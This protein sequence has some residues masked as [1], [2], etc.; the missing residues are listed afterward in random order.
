MKKLITLGLALLASYP[1]PSFASFPVIYG[2]PGSQDLKPCLG[3]DGPNIG[4]YLCTG[5][6]D[7]AAVSFDA[8]KGSIYMRYGPTGGAVY[9]KKDD[10]PSAN[11]GSTVSGPSG[12]GG[13]TDNA[14]V[15]WDG[16]TGGNLQDS[17]ATLSDTGV[18]SVP[19]IQ[20]TGQNATTVPFLDASKNLVSSTTT[21]TQLA[22]LNTVTSALCGINQTCTYTNKSIDGATN[23]LTNIPD[24]ALSV[25]YLK[26]DGSRALTANWNAGAFSGT[27][28]GVVIGSGVGAITGTTSINGLSLPTA[29]DT[30]VGR[31]STD[32]L[33]HKSLL[34]EN[35]TFNNVSDPTKIFQFRLNSMTTGKQVTIIPLQST[36]A[37]I[38]IPDFIAGDAFVTNNTTATLKNKDLDGN[39][40]NNFSN[41]P[42]SATTATDAASTDTIVARDPSGN[43]AAGVI[44]A[45][46]FVGD[47]TGTASGNTT[48]TPNDHG[49]VISS[50][51]NAMDVTSPGTSGQFLI[52]NGPGADPTFQTFSA[53][54]TVTSVTFTGDGVVDSATPSTAV[55]TSGTVT[56]TL[57]TH[58]ANTV[59]AG[60]ATG[61]AAAPTFRN[62]VLL[63]I[64]TS[65]AYEIQNLGISPFVGSNALTIPFK[66]G[67]GTNNCTA[68]AP[69][70]VGF[71]FPTAT[72]GAFNQRS[73][74]GALSV[75]V[76]SGGT[77]GQVSALSEFTYVYLQDNA[78]TVQGCLSSNANFDEGSLITST[79][80]GAG[81]TSRTVLYC[82]TGASGPV[83]KVAR[84]KSTQTTAGTWATSP[85]E[86]SLFPFTIQNVLAASMPVEVTHHVT[87]GGTSSTTNC[88]NTAGCN[89][90]NEGNL[91]VTGG[92]TWNSTANASFTVTTG[93]FGSMPSCLC[94]ARSVGLTSAEP[95][96]VLTTS[97]PVLTVRTQT[98]TADVLFEVNCV[99]QP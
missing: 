96:A 84:I 65:N 74:T 12:G 27:F 6:A 68:A 91:W 78:G 87:I 45:D 82:T 31:N 52:S 26:A 93:V 83:R 50:S 17:L 64:P 86:S 81:S 19:N 71:R 70:K 80:I 47:V 29:P 25:S 49:V 46:S 58:S 20:L 48:Y 62:L 18:L 98:A 44:T 90:F 77:L 33:N 30:L 13:S 73:I 5:T 53:T 35:T 21:P 66:Q 40:N 14:L 10:G 24:T 97:Y 9:F 38:N 79:T 94:S 76:P 37:S 11:W 89:K 41:I 75:T 43:F 85:A 57:L 69:C 7:P 23:T 16:T 55:T 72:G 63:D 39:N 92:P 56:A 60:P 8:P 95:C 34:S 28:N 2:G 3:M 32:I 61:A 59:L 15:R 99:G 88:D 22:F 54:G 4:S 42:N 1:M 51:T 67:D 36:T